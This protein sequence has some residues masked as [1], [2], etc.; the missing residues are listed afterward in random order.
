MSTK[1][2][3]DSEEEKRRFQE[4][5]RQLEKEKLKKEQQQKKD[6]LKKVRAQAQE[7]KKRREEK[8]KQQK[9]NKTKIDLPSTNSTTD[10]KTTSKT[11]TTKIVEEEKPKIEKNYK[12]CLIQIRMFNGSTLR[13]NFP[14]DANLLDV[15][16][17]VQEKCGEE[18]RLG[19]FSI[20]TPFP[21]KEF[22]LKDFKNT[23]LKDAGL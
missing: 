10:S 16:K 18:I 11:T 7:D 23:T 20:I 12:E 15:A 19:E 4:K 22:E 6:L 8:A 17:I 5:Q 2:K 13:E 1:L 21:K 9:E 3:G 14:V